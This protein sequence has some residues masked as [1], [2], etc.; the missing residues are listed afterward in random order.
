MRRLPELQVRIANRTG[1]PLQGGRALSRVLRISNFAVEHRRG[2]GE[3]ETCGLGVDASASLDHD[4]AQRTALPDAGRVACLSCALR[5]H[6]ETPST[7]RTGRHLRM[8]ALR[9]RR[10][11]HDR[12]IE[13][14]SADHCVRHLNQDFIVLYEHEPGSD[15][16]TNPRA[17]RVNAFNLTTKVPLRIAG[18]VGQGTR[19]GRRQTRSILMAG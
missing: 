8:E 3:V 17:H 9:V 1:P 15:S 12:E 16:D 19:E 7:G 2:V 5:E 18:Q 6:N 13:A 4:R 10:T 14:G 11:G